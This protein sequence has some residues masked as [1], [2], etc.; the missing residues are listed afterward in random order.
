MPTSALLKKLRELSASNKQGLAIELGE[1]KIAQLLEILTELGIDKNSLG[2]ELNALWLKEGKQGDHPFLDP[3]TY[4][5]MKEPVRTEGGTVYDQ[6]SI[7]KYFATQQLKYAN[8]NDVPEPYQRI[9]IQNGVTIA[10]RDVEIKIKA[11]LTKRIEEELYRPRSSSSSSVSSS[12]IEPSSQPRSSTA[13][14]SQTTVSNTIPVANTELRPSITGQNLSTPALSTLDQSNGRVRLLS[15]VDLYAAAVFGRF[16]RTIPISG[17]T[18]AADIE[19]RPSIVGQSSN[20]VESNDP[21]VLNRR[22]IKLFNLQRYEEALRCY[23]R[24]LAF[25]PNDL[26][27]IHNRSAVLIVLNRNLEALESLNRLLEFRPNDPYAL[28]NR[29]FALTMV[30]HY[31]EAIS[32]LN[33]SL[34]VRPNDLE[35]IGWRGFA[36]SLF[37]CSEA[38]L[39]DFNQYLAIRPNDSGM[40]YSRNIVLYLLDHLKEK[41]VIESFRKC[42]KTDSEEGIFSAFSGAT[43]IL[44]RHTSKI[45]LAAARGGNIETVSKFLKLGTSTFILGIDIMDA[46]AG[47]E[48]NG[49]TNIVSLIDKHQA[50]LAKKLLIAAKAGNEND[51]CAFCIRSAYHMRGTKIE[52]DTAFRS[53]GWCALHWAAYGGHVAAVRALLKRF[54]GHANDLTNPAWFGGLFHCNGKQTPAMLAAIGTG[55]EAAKKEIIE[56]LVFCGA[57]LTLTDVQG[58]RVQ[59]EHNRVTMNKPLSLSEKEAVASLIITEKLKVNCNVSDAAGGCT[60]FKFPEETPAN[61]LNQS[62]DHLEQLLGVKPIKSY[63]AGWVDILTMDLNSVVERLRTVTHAPTL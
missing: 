30:G 12:I 47:A 61:E 38:A 39:I 36:C 23:N 44:I 11:F 19:L 24:A 42:A 35:T 59:I 10:A 6:E 60:R 2:D 25:R 52:K 7:N 51:V 46:R 14:I 26:Q 15:E 41:E 40:L 1:L 9:Q 43:R 55:S 62:I 58:Q 22:G 4:E 57:D 13:I 49:H 45:L 17:N 28:S 21:D 32:S 50:D 37:D 29:G 53:S 20:D 63:H 18:S 31:V 27:L 16:S 8:T 5:I 56:L 48:L 54:P 33:Q 3:L 34:A